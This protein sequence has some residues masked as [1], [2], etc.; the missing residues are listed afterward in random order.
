MFASTDSSIR[1]C[2]LT[3]TCSHAKGGPIAMWLLYL[4]FSPFA[5]SSSCVVR[6][7]TTCVTIRLPIGSG[8]VAA[9]QFANDN[10]AIDPNYGCVPVD[11]F[12]YEFKLT[13]GVQ[14]DSAIATLRG[15][16]LLVNPILGTGGPGNRLRLTDRI[17]VVFKEDIQ[18][19]NIELLHSVIGCVLDSALDDSGRSVIVRI[20]EPEGRSS[21]DVAQEYL[22]SGSCVRAYPEAYGLP[23]LSTPVPGDNRY[24]QWTCDNRGQSGGV[25]DKDID[26][27]HAW[28]ASRGDSN[29]TIAVIEGGF[30]PHDDTEYHDDETWPYYN[31]VDYYD[32]TGENNVTL[33]ICGRASLLERI[34]CMH[35]TA[36]LGVMAAAHNEYGHDGI[37]PKCHY[38]ALRVGRVAIPTSGPQYVEVSNFDLETALRFVRGTLDAKIVV[39]TWE[40]FPEFEVFYAGVLNELNLLESVS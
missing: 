11:S 22:S 23:D 33:S 40:H 6:A 37:A 17:A 16:G 1:N 32:M 20:S 38:A 21:L 5:A 28:R 34:D 8:D 15:E 2:R 4:L 19:T 25:P 3:W 26:A 36:V 24:L 31:T 35:G 12:C 29:V 14:S 13:S 18:A 27:I 7:D 10:L 30:S 39:L 9:M